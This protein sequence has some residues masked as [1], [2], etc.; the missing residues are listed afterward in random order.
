MKR[1]MVALL[2]GVL[3][4]NLTACSPSGT[5][6]LIEN[7]ISEAPVARES[8]SEDVKSGKGKAAGEKNTSEESEE[9][10]EAEEDGNYEPIKVDTEHFPDD[11]FRKYVSEVIDDDRDG[12]ISYRECALVKDID[13][14]CSWSA[15]PMYGF[16]KSLQGIE[17]FMNLENL[18]VSGQAE[19]TSIDLSQNPKLLCL[20]CANCG[21]T[22]LDTSPCTNLESLFCDEDGQLTVLKL[23]NPNLTMLS[24]GACGFSNLDLRSCPKLYYLQISS[25][26][27]EEIDLSHNPDLQYFHANSS[28]LK[29]L[30]LSNNSKLLELGVSRT[31]LNEI[32]LSHTPNIEALHFGGSKVKAID[33]NGIKKLRILG[34]ELTELSEIDVST[35]EALEYLDIEATNVK[36]LDINHNPNL[37][38]LHLEDSLVKEIDVTKCKEL[39]ELLEENNLVTEIT[40]RQF[41]NGDKVEG[42]LTVSSDCKVIYK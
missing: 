33:V 23:D 40:D 4:L 12:Y 6:P 7:S 16:C 2:C 24:C 41:W 39:V 31:N 20:Y 35:N 28:R 32:D 1:K 25:S 37:R 9:I 17:F 19:L 36:S 22:S 11:A 42:Q 10:T 8:V 15:E 38:Y 30:D 29:A 3:I 21:I 34:A 14:G 13:L 27:L 5:E 26:P 18:D